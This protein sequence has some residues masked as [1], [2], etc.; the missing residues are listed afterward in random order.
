MSSL[1]EARQDLDTLKAVDIDEIHSFVNSVDKVQLIGYCMFIHLDYAS[2]KLN[3]LEISIEKL[4]NIL[5]DF[6]KR[7]N[8]TMENKIKFQDE[9]DIYSEI[10]R[11]HESFRMCLLLEVAHF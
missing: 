4:T 7:F 5:D 9:N 11:V 6:R 2:I 3:R 1:L 8:T 10:F